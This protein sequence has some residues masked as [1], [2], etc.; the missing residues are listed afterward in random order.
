MEEMLRESAQAIDDLTS[1]Y[2]SVYLDCVGDKYRLRITR[3]YHNSDP[4]ITELMTGVEMMD[5]M[6]WMLLGMRIASSW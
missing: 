3:Y 2:H 1:F 5:C 6:K 4:I